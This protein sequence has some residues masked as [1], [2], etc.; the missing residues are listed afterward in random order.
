VNDPVLLRHFNLSRNKSL[1]TLE[2][3]AESVIAA[4]DAA[5]GSL[6]TVLS[7]VTSPVFLNVVIVYQD[8]DIDIWAPRFIAISCRWE[9]VRFY[10]RP[11]EEKAEC[12]LHH[13]QAF[14]VFHE[15]HKVRE[16]QLVLCVDVLDS[17]VKYAV[18]MLRR[19]V[20][21]EQMEGRLLYEPLIIAE[22]RAP[23]TRP[24]DHRAGISMGGYTI[25]ASAL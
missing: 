10:A 8:T 1:Q 2:T 21:T 5:S 4:G 18:R 3:T 11:P 19:L 7:T 25:L 20:K 12:I 17:V 22:V 24:Q 16:F 14:K 6:R 15:M 9:H 23:R 13:Q